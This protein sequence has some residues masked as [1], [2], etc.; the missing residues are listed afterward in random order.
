MIIALIIVFGG[1]IGFNIFKQYMT[2]EFL[3]TFK[4]P[5]V[6]ISTVI[7][8]KTD[9]LPTIPAVGNFTAVNGVDV[10]AQQSG[11][12]TKI[13][14]ESGDYVKKGQLLIEIDHSIDDASLAEAK[15]NLLLAK[16]NFDRQQ[17]LYKKA[18]TSASALDSARSTMQQS[19][20]AVSKIEATIA[21]KNIRAPFSGKLGVRLVNLG[22]F[23]SPG[24]TQIVTLQSQDPLFLQFYLPEQYLKQL[25]I[26]QPILFSVDAYKNL[27]FQ[28]KIQAINSKIDTNTHNVLVQAEV[29]N[30]PHPTDI[31][32]Q[33]DLFKSHVEKTSGLTVYD[34]STETNQKYNI[35]HFAFVPGMFANISVIKPAQKNVMVLP[36]S[37]INYS[38]YGNSV[39]VVKKTTDKKT[40][41]ESKQVFQKFVKTGEEKG[42]KVVILSGIDEGDEIVNSG[43]IK[44]EN[45]TDVLINNKVK[46]NE[47]KDIDSLGE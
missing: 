32:N 28:G 22:Q 6:T 15:A 40:K 14:F 27:N 10:N 24:S 23:I 31:N 44:L 46:L 29:A 7:A 21:Q 19:E 34:C 37:S 42:T 45:G 17:S 47:V 38:L 5:P 13:D 12:V 2:A 35:K 3:K 4:M 41:K 39:Y 11:H 8:K 26:G 30:C 9:W 18:A 25:S 43:Q 20:A 36:R 1:L 16:I 33:K